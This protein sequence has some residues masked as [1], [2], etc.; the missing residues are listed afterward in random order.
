MAYTP[1]NPNG[2]ATKANSAPV[3]IA[4]DQATTI[5]DG[6]GVNGMGIAIVATNFAAGPGNTTTAQLAAAATFTGTVETIFAQQAISLL[7]TS[8]QNGTLIVNQYIDAAGLRKAATVTYT[9]TAGVGFSRSFVAN[10]N[11]FNLTFQNNG[12]ATTTTLN[13]NTFYGTLP[14]STNR[15][16][17]P[18]SLDE[19]NGTSFSAV[20]KNTQGAVAIPVQRMQDA[21]RVARNFIL[22]TFTAAPVAD[23]LQSVAQWFNNAAV[24]ATTQPA[25]VTAGKTLR[26]FGWRLETKSLAT[27][28]SVIVRVR[29]NT[30]GLVAIGSPL[31]FSFSAGSIAGATTVAMTGAM[32]TVTG[33]FPEGME[34]PAGTGIG[35]SLAGYG[36]TGVLT[37]QGVTRFEVWGYEY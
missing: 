26:L 21:G 25:V 22:D 17:N 32:G 10:G 20:A 16:N 37:L 30:A 24:A 29:A 3:V 8:D 15:G 4:S 33:L 35:F 34:L 13:I 2:Q 1:N 6:A 36:P 11:Y 12:G 5:S 28:G 27:V 19:I 14:N 31:V 18:V 9:I 7:L 23:A